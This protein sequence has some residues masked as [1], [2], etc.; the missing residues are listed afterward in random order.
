MVVTWVV[1][2]AAL[3][4]LLTQF[5]VTR[6]EGKIDISDLRVRVR[7]GEM[8]SVTLHQYLNVD[9]NPDC[10]SPLPGILIERERERELSLSLPASP[11][12]SLVLT[13]KFPSASRNSA[14]ASL[15]HTIYYIHIHQA[16][17]TAACTR[18]AASL[19]LIWASHPLRVALEDLRLLL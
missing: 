1:G 12:L 18:R 17:D 19:F 9:D 15:A 14:I 5:V 2:N 13:I 8:W 7:H 3:V 16:S 6:G 11:T 10:V 4:T